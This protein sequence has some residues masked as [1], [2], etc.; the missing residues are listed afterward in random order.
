MKILHL[1]PSFNNIIYAKLCDELINEGLSLTA[2]S[3]LSRQSNL[4]PVHRD[5]C[6]YQRPFNDIDRLFFFLKEKKIMTMLIHS[7]NCEG[8]DIVHAH[9]LFVSGYIAYKLKK[10]YGIPYIVAVRNSDI[11]I[12]YKYRFYLR[13]LGGKILKEAE[14]IV[15]LSPHAKNQLFSKYLKKTEVNELE[16]K[17]VIIPNGI[18]DYWHEHTRTQSKKFSGYNFIFWGDIDRNKNVVNSCKSLDKIVKQGQKVH[19]YVIGPCKDSSVLDIVKSYD[20]VEYLGKSDK[21]TICRYADSSSI[22]IMPSFSET[23]GLSYIEAMSQGLPIIY[24]K[25]QGPDGY[26]DKNSVGC[27]V[28]PNNIQSICQGI[29]VIVGNYTQMSKNAINESYNF[30]WKSVA[31]TYKQLYKGIMGK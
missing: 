30:S 17:T 10:R 14:S 16:K 20:F 22:Y 24:S 3:F 18:D 7:C 1:C 31:K 4:I 25:G 6:T 23:F 28:D 12:F 13:S 29:E 15:F 8:F 26:F 2:F 9:T 21:E 11:T 19:F 5:Y 27:A